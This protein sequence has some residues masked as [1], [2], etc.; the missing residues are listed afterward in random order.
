[1]RHARR[2]RKVEW[3][4]AGLFLLG[5]LASPGSAGFGFGGIRL[6]VDRFNAVDTSAHLPASSAND[7]ALTGQ[8]TP[9]SQSVIVPVNP[10]SDPPAVPLPPW[11]SGQCDDNYYPGSFVLSSWDGLT[12][13]GPGPNRGGYDAP[14]EFFPGAWG[15]LEWECVELSMRWLY[16]EY[17]VR[18][19]PA[20]GSDVVWNYSP[21]DG[22]DLVKV[23]NDGA[24]VPRAGDVLSM[25]S[26][27]SEGHT[28]VVTGSDVRDGFGSISI[29]E[30]NM[31]GGNGTNTLLVV[32]NVVEPDFGM[33]VTGW[34]QA[35]APPVA[36]RFSP[37]RSAAAVADLVH[38]GGFNHA[39]PGAWHK[40][41][42]ARYSVVL[43]PKTAGKPVSVPFEGYGYAVVAGS[44]PGAG[45][46]Q[47]IST[48]VAAGESFCADAEVVTASKTA[49]AQGRLGLWLLGGSSTQ[50][51]LASFGPLRGR[52][53]WTPVSTCVTAT[54]PHSG[55]RVQFYDVPGTPPLGIDAVDLHQSF[56]VNG[57]FDRRDRASWHVTRHAWLG[58]ESA[59]ELH[60]VPVGGG[61]FAVT[62]TSAGTGGIYQDG[63][64]LIGTG[65]SLCADA[66]VVT[67]GRGGGARGRMELWLL[68]GRPQVSYVAFDNLAGRSHWS[69]IST[70]VTATGAHSGFRI[71]FY[72]AAHAPTLAIDSVDVHQSFVE[73]G[74]FNNSGDA[75]WHKLHR[76]FFAIE[77]S[78]SGA[79]SAYEGPSFGAVA[80]SVP[81][82]G[83]FQQASLPIAT[84]E[85]L[86]A[87][88]EVVTA[89]T[90]AGARGEMVL[91]LLGSSRPESSD[92]DFGPLPVGQWT[93]VSTCLTASVPHSGYRI[94]V[95][96][97]PDTPTLGID[98]VDVR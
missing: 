63:S 74:G 44:R 69:A 94:R 7:F 45:I 96:D 79:T 98:A 14:V 59:G 84:G 78:R 58:L 72:D 13:C 77:A 61:G 33:P 2:T 12:A 85:S 39:G 23:A 73:N 29:L 40:M 46:Y 76:T 5:A 89:A 8:V 3:V 35:A 81:G 54:G 80:T 75:G 4:A 48:P 62:N 25:G 53:N 41:A 90:R 27:W 43:E 15:E 87:D 31:N 92:V 60:T 83:I 49:G 82:G 37:M 51:S 65:D 38:D 67:A 17:G 26:E 10:K 1:M 30:Q 18:P 32:G 47:D 52:D 70:C 57:G 34:L 22:G 88:A 55:I 71:Q 6:S 56:V 97:E 9:V 95:Y 24:S 91:T 50:S 16:L 86:C 36:A 21:A 42:H 68:G 66:F 93:P 11:W 20:N 19:Y 64:L 28:A